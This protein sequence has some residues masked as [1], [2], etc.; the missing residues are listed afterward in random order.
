MLISWNGAINQQNVEIFQVGK[1]DVHIYDI[2][3][4]QEYN[5]VHLKTHNPPPPPHVDS[6]V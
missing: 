5:L 6:G 3:Q 1:V 2:K 4:L